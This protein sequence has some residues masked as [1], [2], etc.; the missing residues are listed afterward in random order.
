M[1]SYTADDKT[2]LLLASRL[3]DK[4]SPSIP[5]GAWWALVERLATDGRPIASL[6]DDPSPAED[7]ERVA[8]L[9]GMGG[10]MA[11]AL[12]A[13]THRG[14]VALPHTS[15]HFP[16]GLVERLGRR[17]PPVLFV[18]GDLD[19]LGAGG[20]GIVGSRDVA[21]EGAEVA[22]AAA[23]AAAR[24]GLQVVSGAARGVD[25]VA[26]AAAVD[27]GGAVVGFV[28]DA[29]TARIRDATTRHLISEGRVTFATT[30]HPDAPFSP[31]AAMERN[32][33]IHATSD[34]TLVVATA[35]GEGGTWAGATES[36]RHGIAPVLVHRGPGEGP[37][38][39]A[40]AAAGGRPVDGRDPFAG[41][42]P[43]EVNPPEAPPE[44]GALFG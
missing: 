36:L 18:A 6:L 39:A 37:G 4:A 41:G 32:K 34:A 38:N 3:A 16:T 19:R 8:Q 23:T 30:Q 10:A 42:W 25:Q 44:Q 22:R 20:L 24:R 14:I 13:I 5:T 35:D 21:P 17:C 15:E 2:V 29:L 33:L 31:G 1:I 9:T 27:A 26:M 12:E 7:P 11:M 43:P 28:A 40:L